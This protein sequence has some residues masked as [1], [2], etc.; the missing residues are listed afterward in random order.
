MRFSGPLLALALAA[1]RPLPAAPSPSS[2]RHAL[3]RTARLEARIEALRTERPP[4]QRVFRHLGGY[5]REILSRDGKRVLFGSLVRVEGRVLRLREITILPLGASDFSRPA[6]VGPAEVRS[7]RRAIEA[8]ARR[9]GFSALILE[10]ERVSG[11]RAG[12]SERAVRTAVL[13]IKE[14]K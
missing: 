10:G 4:R 5:S 3:A 13:L 14:E 7:A 11:A 2:C 6:D 9:A 8:D 1:S 12:K